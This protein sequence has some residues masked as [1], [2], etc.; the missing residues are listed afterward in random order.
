MFN[1]GVK[2]NELKDEDMNLLCQYCFETILPQFRQRFRAKRSVIYMMLYRFYKRELFRKYSRH[3]MTFP[4][5][6]RINGKT[7]I[8]VVTNDVSVSGLSVVS[9]VSLDLDTLIDVEVITPCGILAAKGK[10]K[11]VKEIVAMNTY[12]IGVEFIGISDNSRE[13]L[14]RLVVQKIESVFKKQSLSFAFVPVCRHKGTWVSYGKGQGAYSKQF[15]TIGLTQQISIYGA[16][17]A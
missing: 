8:T 5:V 13:I 11:Q 2:F 4:V 12:F 16:I 6:I 7:P 15:M 3:K 17:T 10:I 9:Y 14:T 1:Y